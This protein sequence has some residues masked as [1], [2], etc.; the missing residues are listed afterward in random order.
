MGRGTDA[1]VRG[2][3]AMAACAAL[4]LSA[5]ATRTAEVE[6]RLILPEGQA[7]YEMAAHQ[8][9][10]FPRAL[11]QTTPAFPQDGL[12]R[13]LPPTTVCA[14]LVVDAD[15][16]VGAVKPLRDPGC[17]DPEAQ[18]R[19]AAAMLEAVSSWRFVPAMFCIYPDA[20]TR[21]RDWNGD[22]CAGAV[23]EA[24]PVAVTLAYAFTFE[25]RNGRAQVGAARLRH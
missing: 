4:A 7:R 11:A 12:P 5:C 18:P 10:V 1:A 13:A 14:S 2:S 9:F 22:G 23:A 3:M 24:R 16:G 17:S 21:D 25:V 20:A 6:Q 19:L 8:A 15:G